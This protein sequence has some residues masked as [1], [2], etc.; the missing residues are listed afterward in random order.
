MDAL[1]CLSST[2]PRWDIHRLALEIHKNTCFLTEKQIH[3]KYT[4]KYT[5]SSVTGPPIA[6]ASYCILF[7]H[8]LLVVPIHI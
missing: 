7:V 8:V 1:L 6:H 3:T 4:A 2:A 5:L